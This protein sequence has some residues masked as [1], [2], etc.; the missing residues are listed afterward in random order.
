MPPRNDD[1]LDR[2]V[3]FVLG[4]HVGQM[5]AIERWDLVERV[6]GEVVPMELR[7]DDNLQDREIRYSVG[8][9]REQ[10]LLICDLGD[11]GG[12]WTAA[13]ETEFWK[14]YSYYT[15]PIEARARVARKMKEAA[16]RMLPNLNQPSLFDGV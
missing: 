13:N 16:A 2:E 8:R 14:F 1:E 3:R 6:F 4:M 12:R 7:N 9:L 10:G 11:G 15:K 5:N